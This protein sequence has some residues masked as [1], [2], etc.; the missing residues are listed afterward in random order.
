MN[1]NL[2]FA[3]MEYEKSIVERLALGEDLPATSSLLEE[4]KWLEKNERTR[5]GQTHL[6]IKNQIN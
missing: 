5:V 6:F 2:F 4:G 1:K 3:V